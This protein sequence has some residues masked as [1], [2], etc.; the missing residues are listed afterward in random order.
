LH[1]RGVVC[2]NR[3]APLTFRSKIGHVVPTQ[4]LEDCGNCCSIGERP[5]LTRQTLTQGRLRSLS[6]GG[7]IRPDV[8]VGLG[9]CDAPITP[10]PVPP[11]ASSGG[12]EAGDRGGCG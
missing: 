6:A 3:V 2:H 11:A 4:Q 8:Y 5:H 9:G 1:D 10:A 7:G 12:R